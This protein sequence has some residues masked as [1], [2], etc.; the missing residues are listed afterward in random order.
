MTLVAICLVI[1]VLQRMGLFGTVTEILWRLEDN[2]VTTLTFWGHVTSSFTWPFDSRE[3]TSYG[4]SILTIRL[5]STVME[6]WPFEVLPGR[7]FQEQ[8]S[9]VGRSSIFHWSD[10]LFFATLETWRARSKNALTYKNFWHMYR[11]VKLTFWHFYIYIFAD[12]CQLM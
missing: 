8:R 3:L 11:N 1:H 6:I 10:I 7:L 9:V 12:F 2:W 4:W 5:S